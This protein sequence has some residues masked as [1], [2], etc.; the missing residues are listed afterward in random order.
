VGVVAEYIYIYKINKKYK[1]Q[2]KKKKGG[3]EESVSGPRKAKLA[4]C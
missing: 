1:I 3:E 2:K 4:C